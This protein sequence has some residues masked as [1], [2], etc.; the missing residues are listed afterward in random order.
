[1]SASAVS[2]TRWR[3]ASLLFS[4]LVWRSSAYLL[5]LSQFT[6]LL[7]RSDGDACHEPLAELERWRTVHRALVQVQELAPQRAH[8]FES[9][10]CLSHPPIPSIGRT[11]HG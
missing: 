7:R 5:K 1:M 2:A 4:G 9:L 11:L 6:H 10:H 3:T 8:R